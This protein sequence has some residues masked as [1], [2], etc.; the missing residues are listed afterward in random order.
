MWQ[1]A[2]KQEKKLRC[3][4]IDYKKRAE[5]RQ[6]YYARMRMDPHQLMR[7]YGQKCKF[8]IFGGDS[9]KSNNADGQLMPWQGDPEVMIDRFDVRAHLDYIP[10]TKDSSNDGGESQMTA[11]EEKFHRKCAYESYRTLVQIDATGASEEQYL[12]QLDLEETVSRSEME[13]KRLIENDKN[14]SKAKAKF[15]YKYEDSTGNVGESDNSDNDSDSDDDSDG[16]LSDIDI[17]VNVLD[18]AEDQTNHLDALATQYGVGYGQYCKQ[19]LL[20]KKEFE[21]VKKLEEEEEER[22]KM[23][24]RKG[25]SARRSLRAKQKTL[26]GSP[27]SFALHEA[28][29]HDEDDR[30]KREGSASSDSSSHSKTPVDSKVEFITS[31]GGDESN[32]NG[33]EL[34]T[35]TLNPKKKSDD[36]KSSHKQVRSKSRS[37]SRSLEKSSRSEHRSRDKRRSRSRSRDRHC[38]HHSTTSSK[39]HDRSRSSHSRHSST[40]SRNDSHNDSHNNLHRSRSR[41]PKNSRSH[42]SRSRSPQRDKSCGR[43]RSK[44]RTK[45]RSR[46]R[47]NSYGKESSRKRSRSRS[48][49]KSHDTDK[50]KSPHRTIVKRLGTDT[51]PTPVVDKS[52]LTPREKMKLRMQKLLNRQIKSDKKE[53]HKKQAAKEQEV[54]ERDMEI[55][56]M[57]RMLR[58]K[59][60]EKRPYRSPSPKGHIPSYDVSRVK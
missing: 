13:K 23:P 24:G 12:K 14:T 45:R 40:K 35:L 59:E 41:S 32:D 58:M 7:V 54:E 46:S 57:S 4:M 3:I 11:E 52:A 28:S 50:S 30:D 18:L 31:F 15:H 16:D 53:E 33:P 38:S 39:S 20:E 55:Y 6:A 60:R 8:H 29:P 22:A 34:P 44:G 5:R 19:L 21:Y 47:S 10:E 56:E 9:S 37:R 43:D 48:C 26:R 25:K 36:H 51:T 42:R 17:N 49:S 2:R 27:L 1:E